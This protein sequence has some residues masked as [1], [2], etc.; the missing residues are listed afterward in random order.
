VVTATSRP[1]YPSET[2]WVPTVKGAL[3]APG[4][5]WTDA[6]ILARTGIRYS[7][8]APCSEFLYRL[9]YL[10][11]LI[12]VVTLL[13]AAVRSAVADVEMEMSIFLGV[14]EGLLF[15]GIIIAALQEFISVMTCSS[16]LAVPAYRMVSPPSRLQRSVPLRSAVVKHLLQKC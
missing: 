7:D 5:V 10:L 11:Q 16:S 13:C 3:W 12:V 15:L 14:T 1:L 8:R 9:S 4:P 6:E 2:D